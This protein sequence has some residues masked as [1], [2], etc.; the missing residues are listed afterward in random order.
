MLSNQ[1]AFK[2]LY[3]FSS[4][5]V[6]LI[7]IKR[8]DLS[9]EADVSDVYSWLLVIGEKVTKLTFKS[10][11]KESKEFREFEEGKLEFDDLAL[12]TFQGTKFKLKKREILS[13]KTIG[14]IRSFLSA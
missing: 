5:D 1:P 12:L 13:E 14:L 4:D 9:P 6:S 10:M 3:S 8:T 2:V 7:E 11:R